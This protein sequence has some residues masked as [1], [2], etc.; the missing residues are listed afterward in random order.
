MNSE[1][2]R[3][4]GWALLE[5]Y[6]HSREAGFVTTVYFGTAAMFRV[7]VPEIPARQETAERP[8]WLDGKLCPIGTVVEAA[9]IPGRTRYLGPGAIYAMNPASED[10]VR[11]AVAR[12]V[13]REVKI[14]SIPPQTERMLDN[15]S[16]QEDFID[17]DGERE[18]ATAEF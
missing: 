11:T 14:I 8:R 16:D 6:G 2:E 9:A 15:P 3:F 5:L 13:D 4:E 7:D 10:A 18:S 12:M 1:N 17:D